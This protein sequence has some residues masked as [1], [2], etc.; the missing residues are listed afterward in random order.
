MHVRLNYVRIELG[1][2]LSLNPVGQLT[3]VVEKLKITQFGDPL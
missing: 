3:G 2:F 1:W